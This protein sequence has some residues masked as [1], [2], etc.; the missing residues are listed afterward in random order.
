MRPKETV[1]VTA[2]C[3]DWNIFGNCCIYPA[4]SLVVTIFLFSITVPSWLCV[5]LLYS[6]P[7]RC[8]KRRILG[9]P[10]R[11]VTQTALNHAQ[12]DWQ[13]KTDNISTFTHATSQ[14]FEVAGGA[15]Y[16]D[17]SLLPPWYDMSPRGSFSPRLYSI[18]ELVTMCTLTSSSLRII[19]VL[20]F[21]EHI[22]HEG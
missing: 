3:E 14:K 19:H 13:I 17:L 11:N 5:H 12:L 1:V 21:R 7:G 6:A 2:K 15:R 16:N 22:H 18:L 10:E 8:G 9:T 20:R 4:E